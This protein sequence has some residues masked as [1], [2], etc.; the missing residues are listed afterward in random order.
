V[1]TVTQFIAS[2]HGSLR[3]ATATSSCSLRTRNLCGWGSLFWAKQRCIDMMIGEQDPPQCFTLTLFH[4]KGRL[5][6]PTVKSTSPLKFYLTMTNRS[7]K[8]RNRTFKPLGLAG[9]GLIYRDLSRKL[10]SSLQNFKRGSILF[11]SPKNIS[12]STN[13]GRKYFPPFPSFQS[14]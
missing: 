8:W 13:R 6:R 12:R 10:K 11:S 5:L 4:P 7:S 1:T 14:Y 3:H 9:G 2:R